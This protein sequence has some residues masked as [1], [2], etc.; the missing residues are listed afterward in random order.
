MQIPEYRLVL[1][2]II[3]WSLSQHEAKYILQ[4]SSTGCKTILLKQSLKKTRLVFES[5]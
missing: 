2:N 4:L 5:W 3:P 1:Q